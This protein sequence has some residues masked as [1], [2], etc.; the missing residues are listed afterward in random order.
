MGSESG[1]TETNPVNRVF[2]G[3]CN[4]GQIV[5]VLW[6]QVFL[7]GVL[8]FFGFFVSLNLFY[9]PLVA[10]RLLVFTAPMVGSV[11]FQYYGGNGERKKGNMTI[12]CY[13]VCYS[14]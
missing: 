11:G 1:Q 8:F 4:A 10:T 14:Y 3:N 5:P 7:C 9:L 13:K 2:Q 6:G 12:K